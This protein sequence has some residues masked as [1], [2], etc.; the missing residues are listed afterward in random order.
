MTDARPRADRPASRLPRRVLDALLW[1]TV[2]AVVAP[3]TFAGSVAVVAFIRNVDAPA[4]GVFLYFASFA[5][6]ASLVFGL[7]PYAALLVG[8][9]LLAPGLG[10][11]DRSRARLAL[12]MA[13]LAIPAAGVAMVRSDASIAT[14]AW[15]WLVAWVG[16]L[17]PRLLV[18][19]LSPGAFATPPAS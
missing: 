7:A 1:T 6:F 14:F 2:A 9:A 10:D 12:A 16:L 8:W 13:V 3:L 4:L 15:I 18:P 11:V 19:R 17:V 5:V